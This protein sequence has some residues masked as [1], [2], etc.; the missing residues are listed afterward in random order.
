MPVLLQTTLVAIL[1]ALGKVL[2]S[3]L[4]S[5]LTEKF[6]KKTIVLALEK[7]ADKTA[8]D[9]DNQLLTAAKEAWYP[10]EAPASPTVTPEDEGKKDA[11]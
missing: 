10:S 2:L 3:M 7:I 1:T 11:K 4:T 9:L 5:L 6:L 8:S